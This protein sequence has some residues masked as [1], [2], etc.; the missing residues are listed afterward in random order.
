MKNY[1]Q[2]IKQQ[3]SSLTNM[4]ALSGEIDDSMGQF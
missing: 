4:S 1:L 2:N 3:I